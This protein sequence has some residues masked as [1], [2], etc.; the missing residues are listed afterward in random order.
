MP[1]SA[2]VV[3]TLENR[4]VVGMLKRRNVIKVYNKQVL[5]RGI[6]EKAGGSIHIPRPQ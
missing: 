1:R 4:W 6:G 5:K 2:T 3:E